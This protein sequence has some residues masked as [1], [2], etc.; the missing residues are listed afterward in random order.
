L[1]R[2][3]RGRMRWCPR[4]A[5][6]CGQP[7]LPILRHSEGSATPDMPE[8]AA[9]SLFYSEVRFGV[10]D[11]V[12]AWERDKNGEPQPN[13]VLCGSKVLRPRYTHS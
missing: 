10:H 4:L 2:H 13:T 6:R 11:W 5:D 1:A 9:D 12:N 3:C 8:I 7:K